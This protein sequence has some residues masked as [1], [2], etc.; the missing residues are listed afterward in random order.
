MYK[1]FFHLSKILV[2]TNEDFLNY[3]NS[4]DLE[5]IS[6]IKIEDFNFKLLKMNEVFN[7]FIVSENPDLIIIEFEKIFIS[8]VAAGGWVFNT[9]N[10]LLMILRHGLWDIPKGHLEKGE[11]LE[12]CAIR[13]V[14]E[15]TGIGSLDIPNYLGISRH[16][17]EE[18]GKWI[19][20]ICHWYK[21]YSNFNEELTPQIKEG[22]EKVEWV[23]TINIRK[24]LKNGWPSILD[25]YNEFLG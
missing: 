21:M 25:F 4:N 22:V 23:E 20:K 11:T 9:K 19:L 13:E 15:E 8:R 10:E 1:V 17:F 16:I 5:K 3:I 24:N 2:G 12:I 7:Y 14:M 18:K 6:K